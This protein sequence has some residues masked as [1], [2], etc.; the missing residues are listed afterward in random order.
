MSALL[1]LFLL[2][3]FSTGLSAALRCRAEEGF[4]LSTLTLILGGYLF[5]L[6]G[7]LPYSGLLLWIPALCSGIF[8]LI[9][10]LHK[11]THRLLS[12]LGGVL[13]FLAA[14]LVLWWLCRGCALSD[15]D[16]FSHWGSSLKITCTTGAL[17]TAPSSSDAF[18]SYPPAAVIWEALLMSSA[19]TGY[20]EDLA[21]FF[22]GL[23]AL[24]LLLYPLK[25]IAEKQLGRRAL[26]YVLL[27]GFTAALYPRGLYMLGVDVLLGIFA[28]LILLAEFLPGEN[29]LAAAVQILGCFALCLVK[30]SGFGLALMTAAAV[31]VHRLCGI[32]HSSASVFRSLAVP[33]GMLAAC[34]AAKGSWAMHLHQMGVAERWQSHESIWAGFAQ[35][36]RGNAPAYRQALPGIF[37]D[38]IAHQRNYGTLIP[39]SFVMWLVLAALLGALTWALW[40]REDRRC[41]LFGF[42]AAL[43]LGIVYVLSLLVT[44]LFLFEESEAS[45]LAS[46]SRYLYTCIE[47]LLVFGFAFVSVA[48]AHHPVSFQLIPVLLLATSLTLISGPQYLIGAVRYAPIHAAQT[49]HDAYLYRRAAL[50]IR[51]LGEEN[52]RL[53]LITA[54]DAGI[55]QMRV[56]YELLPDVLPDSVGILAADPSPDPWVR[57]C[58]WPEWRQELLDGYD[59]VY[60]Y[61]PEPQ[62][63]Q[64]YLPVFMD[65]SQVQVDRMFRVIHTDKDAILET[66]PKITSDPQPAV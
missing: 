17:Y 26:C 5:S 40:P 20:R 15:W 29:R 4:A 64:D 52:P 19:H 33:T 57:Q 32:R 39:F 24:S 30:G 37:W 49:N 47:F 51:S 36:L 60:I 25:A 2:S 44:Y 22:H 50:R 6:A 3:L 8:L 7:L 23:L 41:P 11:E 54:N 62:F 38:S 58:S 28:A 1:I 27:L 34:L 56:R 16:D 43:V 59:Y 42:G 21:L 45:A 12:P 63:V 10:A 9:V 53:Y 46:I 13:L 48:A 14:G 18:K 66:M 61:C 31:L 65:E 55:T 35:L